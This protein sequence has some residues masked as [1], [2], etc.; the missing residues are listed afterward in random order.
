M[1]ARLLAHR[2][3]LHVPRCFPA[4]LLDLH[5]ACFLPLGCH[6]ALVTVRIVAFHDSSH[7]LDAEWNQ[8][9]DILALAHWHTL[10]PSFLHRAS[11]YYAYHRVAHC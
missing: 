4:L 5:P 7:C 11:C 9:N 2:S 10:R 1:V 6:L 8:L 3:F